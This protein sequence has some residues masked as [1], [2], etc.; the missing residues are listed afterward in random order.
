VSAIPFEAGF[1]PIP[2]WDFGISSIMTSTARSGIPNSTMT[3]VIPEIM[4][5]TASSD[6]PFHILTSTIGMG[7]YWL[8]LH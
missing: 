5:S 1:P 2:Q 3:F 4:C 7:S 6:T 8:F